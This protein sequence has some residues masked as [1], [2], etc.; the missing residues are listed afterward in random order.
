M[1]NMIDEM[2]LVYEE[3]MNQLRGTTMSNEQ[4]DAIIEQ[5]ILR[6]EINN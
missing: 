3:I 1:D 4:I 5:L 2:K 6:K